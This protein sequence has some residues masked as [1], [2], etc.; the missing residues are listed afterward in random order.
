MT[1]HACKRATVQWEVAKAGSKA[2]AREPAA[3][4]YVMRR[5]TLKLARH[6]QCILIAAILFRVLT[7][8]STCLAAPFLSKPPYEGRVIDAQ[9]KKPIEGAVVVAFYGRYYPG[10]ERTWEI[11]DVHEAVTDHNGMFSI[12]PKRLLVSPFSVDA[13]TRFRIFKRGYSNFPDE[14]YNRTKPGLSLMEEEQFFRGPTGSEGNIGGTKRRTLTL[15]LVELWPL[16]SVEERI[17]LSGV[18]YHS[19]EH[20]HKQPHMLDELEK[21][22]SYLEPYRKHYP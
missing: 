5:E 2:P 11:A 17:S 19:S 4:S 21:E 7:A 3:K 15:G 8:P 22:R 20:D 16:A 9:T 12:P 18:T 10:I 6:G 14:F 13:P 1:D